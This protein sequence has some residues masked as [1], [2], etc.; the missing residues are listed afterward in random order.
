MS[1]FE[2]M[3]CV[4]VCTCVSVCPYVRVCVCGGGGGGE[5]E[6]S[7]GSSCLSSGDPIDIL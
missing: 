3:L 1:Q 7:C 4:S 2:P 5:N 6:S